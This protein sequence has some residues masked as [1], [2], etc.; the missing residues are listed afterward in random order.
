MLRVITAMRR[1]TVVLLVLFSLSVGTAS[2]QSLRESAARAATSAA[3]LERAQGRRSD[4]VLNGA[5]IG[6][7]AGVATHLVWCS[8]MEPWNICRNDFEGM[9]KFGALGAAIG[10]AADAV[11]REQRASSATSDQSKQ[12]IASPLIGR[13]AGGVRVGVKF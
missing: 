1:N 6:A 3:A 9:L 5:L 12:I 7:A 2:A 8:A 10:I 13:R 4:P 11:I